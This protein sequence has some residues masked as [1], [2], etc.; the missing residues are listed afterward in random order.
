MEMIFNSGNSNVL[1]N[2]VPGKQFK[3]KRGVRQGDP[4]SPLLFVL[5]SELL[6]IIINKAFQGGL[7]QAP[8]PQAHSDFVIVQYADDTLLLMQADASQL[9]YLKDLLHSFA[10]ST[11]LWVNYSKSHMIP[12]NLE[13][14]QTEFLAQTFGCQ[15]GTMPFTYLGLP[16]GTTKP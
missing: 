2:G 8:L 12:I 10:N 7:L 4:L 3:C 9:I 15:I 14:Q 1:L 16:M 11:G 6:Q 13:A 5:A